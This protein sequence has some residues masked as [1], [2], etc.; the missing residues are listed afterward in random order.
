MRK[1][2]ALLTIFSFNVYAAPPTGIGGEQ[3]SLNYVNNIKAPN[4]QVTSLGGVNS[5]M[6]TGNTNLLMNPS[7]EHPTVGTGWTVTSATSSADITNM[8]EGKKALSLAVTGAMLVTQD[9]TINAANISGLQGVASIKIKA[10]GTTGLKVC[11]RNAGAAVTGL[12]VN[13]TADNTWKHISI[14]F[15]LGATSNGIGIA[16]TATGG[17]VIIDDAFVGTSAPFQ[18]VSGARLIGTDVITGC[19]GAWGYNTT[20]YASG[21]AVTGCVHTV[22][23]SASS[24][25]TQLPTIKFASLPAGDYRI[26]YEGTL[27]GSGSATS[28][29]FQFTDGTNTVKETSVARQISVGEYNLPGISQSISYSN[30]Q[31]NVTIELKAKVSAGTAYVYGT[32]AQSGTIKVWY[33]PPA[34]KIYTD[35]NN[36]YAEN[37]G[38]VFAHSGASCPTGS[39]LADGSAVSRATYAD[40]YKAIGITHGQGDGSTT[41]NLP[42]Y[43]GQFLRGTA[44]V[45]SGTGSGTVATNNATFTAHGV[46][47]TG[48]K[49]RLSSGTLSGLVT[50]TDYYAIVVDAN[51]LAFATTKANALAGTKIAITG[52]NSAVI[53]QYEAPDSG[54]RTA[55]NVGGNASGVGSMESD[56]EQKIVGGPI[57]V[58]GD[59][60]S[61]LSGT[62]GAFTGTNTSANRSSPGTVGTFLTNLF[63]DSSR[64]VRTSTETRPVNVAVN[65]CVRAYNRNITGSFAGIE[66]CANDYECTDT[67]SA[68]VSASGVVS[69][70]NIDWIN[71]NCTTGITT[72]C[73]VNTNIKDG[74]S[75]ITSPMNCTIINDN[76]SNSGR[77]FIGGMGASLTT[78]SAQEITGSTNN[79][80]SIVDS[81]T[82][83]CQKGSQDYKPKT[84]KVASSNGV[85]T[86]PGL[87]GSS[88]VSV[89]TFSVSYAGANAGTASSTNCTATPCNIDQIGNIVSTIT[90]IGG[91]NY[92]MTVS[93]TY[94]ALKC[95]ASATQ[96]GVGYIAASQ[97]A[98]KA[99]SSVGF[100]TGAAIDTAGTLICQGTY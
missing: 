72:T 78:V 84:A 27:G 38:E 43:R 8:V 26:E 87:T 90:R 28:Q 19:S 89:D 75:A 10:T 35:F 9:S 4:Y 64:V 81:F 1:L 18:D 83:K 37:A 70:E 53:V 100:G 42:D 5:R 3:G 56:A 67:F 63:F 50:A 88:A 60:F 24:N 65:Y 55:S 97:V 49:V 59:S 58:A 99:C 39:L 11:P 36:G 13:V 69:N 51:T 22:T 98:C 95:A 47:R 48:M 31:S 85:P 77:F 80:I 66:K 73:T 54:T 16:T 86:V 61:A 94:I 71:G 15:I 62:E 40:L 25:S 57:S 17:T 68:K 12:C 20:S 41:F 7:F 46:I 23:G 92:S 21:S 2:I 45:I 79:P 93:K 52:A 32:T 6:E 74:A 96:V 82:L 29:Y 91:G 34:S 30:A 33:F 76:T 14:P 44:P